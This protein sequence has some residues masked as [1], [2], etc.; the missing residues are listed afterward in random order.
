MEDFYVDN[1]VTGCNSQTE[2]LNLYNASKTLFQEAG[3]NLRQWKSN[4]VDFL[5]NLSM[6][7]ND[8]RKTPTETTEKTSDS[9]SKLA[10]LGVQW[11][12]NSNEFVFDL[13]DI[14]LSP[15]ICLL[16]NDRFSNYRQVSLIH[17]ALFH[18]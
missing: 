15:K 3:M 10:V 4:Y 12:R 7:N 16:R 9:N 14:I 13:H 18:P 5:K 1:L 6:H 2:A 8:I 17:S 11:N